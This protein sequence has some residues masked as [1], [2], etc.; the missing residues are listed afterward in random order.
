MVA[1]DMLELGVGDFVKEFGQFSVEVFCIFL[2]FSVVIGTTEENV[3]EII[4]T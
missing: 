1:V 2:G 4:N 3:S